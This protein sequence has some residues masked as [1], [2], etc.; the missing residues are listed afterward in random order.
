MQQLKEQN[1]ERM[2]LQG[3]LT[4]MKRDFSQVKLHETC[5]SHYSSNLTTL[6][7]QDFQHLSPC[8]NVTVD[9]VTEAIKKECEGPR[10]LF[11]YCAVYPKYDK[12]M[13]LMSQGIKNMQ[14]WQM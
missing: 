3:I 2:H 1:S 5:F 12:C 14:P 7:I 4:Y 10:Q 8:Q 11:G 6:K 9:E 13:A